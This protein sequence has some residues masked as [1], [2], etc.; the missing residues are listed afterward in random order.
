MRNPRVTYFWDDVD[1]GIA[2][3]CRDGLALLEQLGA[4]VIEVP[5]P[6]VNDDMM[7]DLGPFERT[8]F[9]EATSYHRGLVRSERAA[10]YSPEIAALLA[11]G[12]TVTAADY[13]DDQR[14]RSIYARQ[15]RAIFADHGLDAFA[16]PTTPEHPQPQV[17]SQSFAVGVSFRLMRTAPMCAFPSLSVPVGFDGDLPVGLCL[18]GLPFEDARLLGIGVAV[19]EEVALWKVRPPVVE[20]LG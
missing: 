12:E 1:E 10:G 19:D 16:H 6:A 7:A 8:V 2:A 18:T 14:L 20:A 13:L 5:V 4:E 9:A 17:P 3:V 15:W 11:D